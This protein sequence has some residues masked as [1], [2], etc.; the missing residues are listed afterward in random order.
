MLQWI[1][2]WFEPRRSPS[3]DSYHPDD[4]FQSRYVTMP[5]IFWNKQNILH[6]TLEMDLPKDTRKNN[7]NNKQTNQK[8]TKRKQSTLSGRNWTTDL[9]IK[10]MLLNSLR[11]ND[12][13]NF[14]VVGRSILNYPVIDYS[15]DFQCH[16]LCT[17]NLFTLVTFV[18]HSSQVTSHWNHY[19][20][21]W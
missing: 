17:S 11:N 18:S 4:L 13:H 12:L 10:S 1:R 14:V 5:V 3:Q 2:K 8:Q 16:A 21:Y 19:F 20:S 7:S 9:W 15:V 6:H